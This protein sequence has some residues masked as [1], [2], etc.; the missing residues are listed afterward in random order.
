MYHGVTRHAR[1]AGLRNYEGKHL[2]ADLFA[3]HMQVIKRSR[4][5]ISLEQMVDGLHAGDALGN[6]V[7]ITFDDGYENNVLEAAPILAD[8]DIPATFF[9]ATGLIGG[10]GFIWPDR[11]EMALE[12]S[13][14]K[15]VNFPG[16]PASMPIASVDEKHQALVAIKRFLKQQPM[17]D[18]E[19]AVQDIADRLEVFDTC[20]DEDYKFM[21]W[22]QARALLCSGFGIGAHTVTHPVL[23]KIPFDSAVN[24]IVKS[25]DTIVRE[26]GQCSSTFCFPNGKS[27]DFNPALQ[28]FCRRYFKAAL[29]TNRGAAVFDDMYELKRLSPAGKG[30]GENIEW[31]LLRGR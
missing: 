19:H 13:R 20:A 1:S 27:D 26:T 29:S 3:Q 16:H 30:R 6:T 28:A 17:N 22:D 23:A 31:T 15:V 9:L 21:N 5:A 8:F 24:E 10:T 2:A 11:I 14:K 7:A 12:R 25:R 18:L 4:R